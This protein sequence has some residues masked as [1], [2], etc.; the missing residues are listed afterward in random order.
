MMSLHTKFTWIFLLRNKNDSLLRDRQNFQIRQMA[1]D[2]VFAGWYITTMRASGICWG[3][4]GKCC[5]TTHNI[6]WV[7]Q[8][9]RSIFHWRNAHLSVELL[10][11]SCHLVLISPN[12]VW[13][14]I[15]NQS[16]ITLKCSI[17][18][19]GLKVYYGIKV[20]HYYKS[21]Y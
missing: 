8:T 3:Q 6:S 1:F 21:S 19:I 17:S 10:P 16:L 5:L 14:L 4:S 9:Q 7:S 15:F 11:G 2:A 13:G 12:R 20:L 18:G